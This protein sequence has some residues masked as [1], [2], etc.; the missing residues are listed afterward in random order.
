MQLAAVQAPT[1]SLKALMTELVDYAGL[2]PPAKLDMPKAVET[3]H[4]CLKSPESWALARFIC[5]VSRVAEFS[6]AAESFLAEKRRTANGDLP[7]VTWRL[8][9]LIDG[10]LNENLETIQRFNH[11]WR[12]ARPEHK[13]AAHAVIDTIEVKVQ[14]PDII[15]QAV[16]LLP[17]ELFAFFEVPLE[18]D[19]RGFATALAGTGEGAKIRTGG[20]TASAFP[21]AER[22]V[23]FLSCMHDAEVPFKA[24]AGLHHPVRGVFPLTY[25]PASPTGTM[26]GFLNVFVAACALHARAIER[27]RLMEIVTESDPAAFRFAPDRLAWRDVEMPTDAVQAARETF[28]ICFGSCSFEE[29][30]ADLKALRWM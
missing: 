13:H 30:V 17:E 9:V 25:E 14:T 10:D 3:F 26:H 4:R 11:A 21:P 2:F 27:R 28:A 12:S 1:G 16:E 15:D 29:P 20:V 8:S 23:E 24:T 7:P 18:G 22:V 19:L 5:P 6:R